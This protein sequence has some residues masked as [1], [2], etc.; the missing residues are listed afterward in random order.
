MQVHGARTAAGPQ[1][2]H[3]LSMIDSA[4]ID[5]E[6]CRRV[7]DELND[8]ECVETFEKTRDRLE[9]VERRLGVELNIRRNVRRELIARDRQGLL[10]END[11]VADWHDLYASYLDWTREESWDQPPKREARDD[12]TEREAADGG[13]AAFVDRRFVSRHSVAVWHWTLGRRSGW[14]AS[15]RG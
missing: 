8:P 11:L 1:V 6:Q 14:T 7:R 4:A 12:G 10:V 15:S 5:L 2:A 13:L 3:N 9:E